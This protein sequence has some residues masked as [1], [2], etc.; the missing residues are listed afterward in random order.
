MKIR[1]INNKPM[2]GKRVIAYSFVDVD[3]E[4]EGYKTSPSNLK[5]FIL[6]NYV[7]E[8]SDENGIAKFTNLTILGSNDILGYI[9]FYWEGVTT[10]WTDRPTEYEYTNMMAPRAFYPAILD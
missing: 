4:G 2:A 6:E 5:L 7:S 9:M 8:L 3:F 1:D 10:I